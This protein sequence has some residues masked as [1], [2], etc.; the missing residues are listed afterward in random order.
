MS[1]RACLDNLKI[2]T[3]FFPG[4]YVNT[5][6]QTVGCK[7]RGI[8]KGLTKKIRDRAYPKYIPVR[9]ASSSS[10]EQGLKFH[11]YME[12]YIKHGYLEEGNVISDWAHQVINAIEKDRGYTFMLSEIFV[13]DT[14]GK[15]C[16]KIDAIAWNK[17]T[18]RIA[19]VSFKTGHD[20]NWDKSASNFSEHVGIAAK[21]SP[22]AQ[23]WLQVYFE[24]KMTS[25]C[26]GVVVDDIFVVLINN[27]EILVESSPPD[28]LASTPDYGYA[29]YKYIM[30]PPVPKKKPKRPPKPKL[31]RKDKAAKP[32]ISKKN[33]YLII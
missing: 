18:D 27:K 9:G 4:M 10:L 12:N 24:K 15:I 31:P 19:I 1:G 25:Q 5:S 14:Q 33:K 29:I 20:S 13:W 26:R 30:S 23:A 17:T 22:Q 21:S 16:T 32:K 3:V 7:G 8:Y 28:K 6:T 11:Q 2:P